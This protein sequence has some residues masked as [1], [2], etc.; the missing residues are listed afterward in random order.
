[1]TSRDREYEFQTLD[2]CF[3]RHNGLLVEFKYR[4]QRCDSCLSSIACTHIYEVRVEG[5][6]DSGGNPFIEDNRISWN[7]RPAAASDEREIRGNHKQ[8]RTL[9]TF[10]GRRRRSVAGKAFPPKH[11]KGRG[12]L[13]IWLRLFSLSPTRAAASLYTYIPKVLNPSGTMP[14]ALRTLSYKAC[15]PS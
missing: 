5:R 8:K 10:T 9:L 3:S 13:P 11:S 6:H 1:M 7:N 4:K 12:L 2:G 15:S 14:S